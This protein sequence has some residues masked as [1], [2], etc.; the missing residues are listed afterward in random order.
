MTT[1]LGTERGWGLLS[2]TVILPLCF[3]FPS[4]PLLILRNTKSLGHAIPFI[5]NAYPSPLA[6]HLLQIK[7]HFLRKTSSSPPSGSRCWTPT[8]PHLPVVC[9]TVPF[10]PDHHLSHCPKQPLGLETVCVSGFSHVVVG[11]LCQ[12]HA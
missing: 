3:G 9:V 12:E 2:I 10:L 6:C 11:E 7:P 4:V 1:P 8:L 5:R